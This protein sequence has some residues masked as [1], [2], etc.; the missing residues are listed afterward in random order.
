M[1]LVYGTGMAAPSGYKLPQTPE[2]SPE[3]PVFQVEFGHGPIKTEPVESTCFYPYMKL[4]GPA[5]KI[6][7]LDTAKVALP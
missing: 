4:T 7:C 6:A 1:L 2:K 3:V 5:G